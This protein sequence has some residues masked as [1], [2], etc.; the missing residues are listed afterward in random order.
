MIVD[1]QIGSPTNTELVISVLSKLL[2]KIKQK[3]L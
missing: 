2:I 1:D 3:N